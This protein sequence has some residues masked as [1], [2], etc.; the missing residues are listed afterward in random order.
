M[1]VIPC[2]YKLEYVEWRDRGKDGSGAPVNI[3]PSSS[4][5]MTK[6]LEGQII[7]IGYKW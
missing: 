6:Q 3:Y 2:H 5:I 1:I 7:K 4:D